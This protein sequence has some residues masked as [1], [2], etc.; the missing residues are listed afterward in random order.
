MGNP[1][2][3]ATKFSVGCFSMHFSRPSF[4]DFAVT[5]FLL[6]L[7]TKYTGFYKWVFPRGLSQPILTVII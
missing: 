7:G 3:V 6:D 5:A 4:Q 1:P 2:E